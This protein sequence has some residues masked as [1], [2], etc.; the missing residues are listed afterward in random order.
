MV[1]D[2]SS[3]NVICKNSKNN[4][5]YL[6]KCTCPNCINQS[7]HSYTRVQK[8]SALMCPHCSKIF[9]QDKLPLA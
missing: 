9:T 3:G 4:R 8:G 2:H 5:N 6:I 7:E 1:A